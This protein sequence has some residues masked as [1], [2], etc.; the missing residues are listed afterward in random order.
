MLASRHAALALLLLGTAGCARNAIL[1]VEITLPPRAGEA[2]YALIELNPDELGDMPFEVQWAAVPLEPL[3]LGD[4]P[5]ST[6]VSVI[7]EGYAGDALLRIR[8]CRSP[9]CAEI[10]PPSDPQQEVR[11]RIE[12]PFYTGARTRVNLMV[13]LPSP[14]PAPRGCV[15]VVTSEPTYL[16]TVER[17]AVQGCASGDVVSNYCIADRHYCEGD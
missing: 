10:L 1:E 13:P 9:D 4:A 8:F 6:S 14:A 5:V 12:R 11:Y 2:Q 15:E 16:C 7:A 17:C 3:A